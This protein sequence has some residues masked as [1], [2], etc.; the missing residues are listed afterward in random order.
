MSILLM[1]ALFGNVEDD[2]AKLRIRHKFPYE[3][4]DLMTITIIHE[5]AEEATICNFMGNTSTDVSLSVRD[6]ESITILAR[7]AGEIVT[8]GIFEVD[9]AS[10]DLGIPLLQRSVH[11]LSLQQQ[12]GDLCDRHGSSFLND[13]VD[14]LL[15]EVRRC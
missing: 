3:N 1:T 9:I 15:K 11:N 6:G 10:A 5:H 2:R 7:S 4:A 14:Q 13:A 12:V 8:S